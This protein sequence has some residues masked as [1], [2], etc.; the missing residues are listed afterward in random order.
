MKTQF[1]SRSELRQTFRE[2]GRYFRSLTHEDRTTFED[3]PVE[4]LDKSEN[5]VLLEVYRPFRAGDI[6]EVQWRQLGDQS[7]IRVLEVRWSQA[8]DSS[9]Y[10]IGCRLIFSTEWQKKRG[11]ESFFDAGARIQPMKT[12]T[13]DAR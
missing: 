7:T 5:G 12:P 10:N 8:K 9:R 4:I 11:R 13:E 1:S 2:T 6:I 3:G